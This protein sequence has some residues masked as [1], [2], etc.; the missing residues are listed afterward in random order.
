[1]NVRGIF[2]RKDSMAASNVTASTPAPP[3]PVTVMPRLDG[4]D[5]SA[6]L[7]RLAGLYLEED[8]ARRWLALLRPA[9][10][11][12]EA[13]AGLQTVA[14]LGGDPVVPPGFAWPVWEGHGP[15]SFVGEVDLDA[16]AASG[17]A[18]DITLPTSGRLLLFYF[19][20]SYDDFEGI[21]GTWDTAS[22]RGQRL[23]HLSAVDSSCRPMSAPERVP[24]FRERHF[25][26]R[27]T[28]TAPN[29]EHPALHEE[30]MELGQDD[31]SFM[32][33]PVNQAIFVES[34]YSM[35]NGEPL[36]QIGGWSF[37]DQGPVENEVAGA[38]LDLGDDW[39]DPRRAEEARRWTLLVQIDSDADM[40]WGDV[41]KLYWLARHEDLDRGDLSEVSFTWQCG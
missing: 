8:V 25:G 31:R 23:L 36:H 37:P 35:G 30:F 16:L 27:A 1:M 28:L 19:D 40:M 33:H 11:L 6:Y 9:V 14:R 24:A 10:R 20:G 18:L 17:L 29:W 32:D 39:Q 38:A 15:L 21:V 26:A 22:L 12:T 34:I 13:P 4:E 2:R 3:E 7:H 5:D 41:G